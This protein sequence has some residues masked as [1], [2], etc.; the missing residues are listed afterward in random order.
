MRTLSIFILLALLTLAICLA[1]YPVLSNVA[2]ASQT[3]VIV[4]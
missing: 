4:W 1:T 2:T 3:E